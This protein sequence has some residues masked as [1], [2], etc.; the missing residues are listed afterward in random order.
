M[1]AYLMVVA[2]LFALDVLTRLTWF[3]KG[4]LPP[5]NWGGEA[6]NILANLG[7]FAWAI[8]LLAGGGQ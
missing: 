7:F 5:R 2:I 4:E 6:F 1:K 8:G 3:G